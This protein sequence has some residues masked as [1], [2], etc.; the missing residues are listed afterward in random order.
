MEQRGEDQDA[1]TY[2]NGYYLYNDPANYAAYPYLESIVEALDDMEVGEVALVESDYGYHVIMKYEVEK[3]AYKDKDNKDWFEG[4]EAGL[5]EDMFME[6]CKEHMDKVKV[7]EDVLGTAPSMKQ[8]G[9]N[10]YY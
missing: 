8:V 2:Q 9:K 10:Y 4:F 5:I 1:Q 3:D 6:L 7:H